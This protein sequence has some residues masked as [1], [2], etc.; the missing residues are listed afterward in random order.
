MKR[1]HDHGNSYKGKYLPGAGLQVQIFSP[2]SSWR[3]AWQ[4][5]GRCV[6]EKLLIVLQLDPRAAGREKA[7]GPG[8]GF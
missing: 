6:A 3:A 1:H 5:A 4:R 2:I 7:T 8:L